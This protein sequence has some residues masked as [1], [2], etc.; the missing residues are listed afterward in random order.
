MRS[1]KLKVTRAKMPKVTASAK[2]SMSE[3]RSM[4]R[5]MPMAGGIPVAM[6]RRGKR[7]V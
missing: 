3:E 5:E 6:R 1:K 2:R 4:S 7:K